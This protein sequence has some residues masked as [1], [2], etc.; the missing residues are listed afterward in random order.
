MNP[1]KELKAYE[2][3][4]KIINCIDSAET[5]EH[6]QVILNMINVFDKRFEN[7]IM[8]GYLKYRLHVHMEKIPVYD[9]N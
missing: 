6:E 2:A 8:K 3:V 7:L 4:D 1:E 5:T 9:E